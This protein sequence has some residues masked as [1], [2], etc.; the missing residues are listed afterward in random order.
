MAL[1]AHRTSA[2]STLMLLTV[3]E[4]Y[5][6]DTLGP[7]LYGIKFMPPSTKNTSPLD[8]FLCGPDDLDLSLKKKKLFSTL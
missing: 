7:K 4:G 3:S 5:T 6:R 8:V 1:P 2:S